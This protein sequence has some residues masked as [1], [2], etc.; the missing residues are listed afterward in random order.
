MAGMNNTG[1][2]PN[3]GQTYYPPKDRPDVPTFPTPPASG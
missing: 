1:Y 3:G 2:V